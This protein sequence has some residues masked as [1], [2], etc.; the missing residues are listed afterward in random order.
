MACNTILLSL[1]PGGCGGVPLRPADITQIRGVNRYPNGTIETPPLKLVGIWHDPTL[2]LTRRAQ[3]AS[4]P[5]AEVPP[6]CAA[7]SSG[8]ESQ[9]LAL[10]QQVVHDESQQRQH[11]VLVLGVWPCGDA[12]SVL[13]AVADS[14]TITYLKRTYG[15]VDVAGWLSP[16]G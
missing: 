8:R 3:P 16:A 1:P 4:Y 13:V 2:T 12:L 15:A 14:P 7:Q 10:E 9:L 5:A 6:P 11:G